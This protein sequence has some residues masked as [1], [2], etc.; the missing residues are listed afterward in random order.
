[1]LLSPFHLFHRVFFI[2][3][4]QYQDTT[5][6]DRHTLYCTHTVNRI[7]TFFCRKTARTGTQNIIFCMYTV[8]QNITFCMHTSVGKQHVPVLRILHIFYCICI[9]YGILLIISLLPKLFFLS[10][11]HDLFFYCNYFCFVYIFCQSSFLLLFF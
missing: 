8:Q 1:M 5:Q 7:N 6:T 3:L 4:I 2:F 10:N 9:Q 11:A